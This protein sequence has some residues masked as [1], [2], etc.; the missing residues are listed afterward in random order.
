M[1]YICGLC[2]VW[3]ERLRVGGGALGLFLGAGGWLF[4]VGD[5]VDMECACGGG[6]WDAVKAPKAGFYGFGGHM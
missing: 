4:M 1:G 2:G 6:V 3:C 5:G